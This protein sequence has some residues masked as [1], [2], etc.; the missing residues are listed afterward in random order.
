METFDDI[1]QKVHALLESSDCGRLPTVFVCCRYKQQLM[2]IRRRNTRQISRRRLKSYKYVEHSQ[3]SPLA[4]PTLHFVTVSLYQL[5]V[6]LHTH[7]VQRLRDQIKTWLTSN[8][9]KDKSCLM[10]NRKTIETVSF[11]TQTSRQ[12]FLSVHLIIRCGC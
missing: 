1:W 3:A 4:C 10:D 6:F 11:S 5:F 7:N 12:P 8:D 2:P 9:I